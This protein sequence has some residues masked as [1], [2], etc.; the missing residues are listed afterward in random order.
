MGLFP[1]LYSQLNQHAGLGG[2]GELA[3]Q[4]QLSAYANS[5]GQSVLGY[6]PSLS[7]EKPKERFKSFYDELKHET[8][9]WLRDAL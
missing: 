7:D 4:Q 2:L 5:L 8:W 6:I 9:E 3:R 1:D